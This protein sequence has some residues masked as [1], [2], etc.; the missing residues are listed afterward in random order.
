MHSS[1]SRASAHVC[2][3]KLAMKNGDTLALTAS[4]LLG[5]HEQ[6]ALSPLSPCL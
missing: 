2:T 3:H 1:P 6:V 5:D 4:D